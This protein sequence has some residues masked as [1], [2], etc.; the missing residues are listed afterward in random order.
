[1]EIIF[2][3]TSDDSVMDEVG[4][5]ISGKEYPVIKLT[6]A[7]VDKHYEYEMEVLALINE[8]KSGEVNGKRYEHLAMMFNI[9]VKILEK[10]K[11]REVMEINNALV[12]VILGRDPVEVDVEEV[13]KVPRKKGK[14]PGGES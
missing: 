5:E 14:S 7:V 8:G 10:M 9:D 2:S 1:M 13:K 12:R 6:R 3:G 4:I 11:H